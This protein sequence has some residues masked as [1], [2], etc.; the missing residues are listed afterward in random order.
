[1]KEKKK[2]QW[3]ETSVQR[4]LLRRKVVPKL[5]RERRNLKK[6]FFYIEKMAV[7]KMNEKKMKWE[8]K[9]EKQKNKRKIMKNWWKQERRTFSKRVSLK[10][11]ESKKNILQ[12]E[13]EEE[14]IEQWVW[15]KELNKTEKKIWIKTKKNR[16]GMEKMIEI[17]LNNI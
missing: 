1:M 11:K 14:K 7:K 12:M 6:Y 17:K 2:K 4:K 3:I 8:V 15:K 13:N 5:K 9:K 10:F 16:I